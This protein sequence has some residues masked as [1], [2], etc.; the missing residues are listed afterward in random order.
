MYI[1]Y[2]ISSSIYV[3]TCAHTSSGTFDKWATRIL[4]YFSTFGFISQRK[5]SHSHHYRCL[6]VQLSHTILSMM[7]G[8]AAGSW[9]YAAAS[10]PAVSCWPFCVDKLY[11]IFYHWLLSISTIADR[12]GHCGAQW[13]YNLQRILKRK[14]AG[15]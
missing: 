12:P 3:C 2:Y 7:P 14:I 1:L 9:W 11:E 15:N 8:V 4:R 13:V 10:L 5:K 6:S